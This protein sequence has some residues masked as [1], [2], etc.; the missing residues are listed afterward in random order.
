MVKVKKWSRRVV[1][2]VAIWCASVLLL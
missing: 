2:M 1:W